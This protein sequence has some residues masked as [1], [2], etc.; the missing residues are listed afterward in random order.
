MSAY[1]I[2][3]AVA[4]PLGGR[5]GDQLGRARVFRAGLVA[6][7]GVLAGGRVL[8]DVPG[9]DPAP[10]G[11]GAGR[12]G[13]DPQRHGD[14]AGDTASDAAGRSGGLTGSAISISAA[15]GP[16]LGAGL[17]ALGSWRLLFLMNVPLV[18]LA[19]VSLALL[20]YPEQQSPKRRSRWTGPARWRSR[21]CW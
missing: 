9:A 20:S 18:R 17:L 4:Q 3:M 2:A 19:L 5:L 13:G 14:A 1:L 6:F 12:R 15:V 21:R 11:P 16:L 7:P 10:H 8:A